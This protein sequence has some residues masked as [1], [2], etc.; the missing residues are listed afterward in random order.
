MKELLVFNSNGKNV[1]DSRDVAEMTG[2]RHDHLIRDIAG[3]AKILSE[4]THPKSGGSEA[5][6]K[7]APSDFFCGC[8]RKAHKV[9]DWRRLK[10]ESQRQGYGVKKIFDANYGEVNTY[11][12]NVWET[13]YP[14]MEL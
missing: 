2:K 12:V 9:F 6:R 1:V 4:N 13:V 5:E 7:I 11:H 3:Y 8:R 14:N 10:L